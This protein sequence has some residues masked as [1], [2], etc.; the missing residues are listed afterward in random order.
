MVGRTLLSAN[1]HGFG[2]E[3]PKHRTKYHVT[4]NLIQGPGSA[5][6]RTFDQLRVLP[7]LD[8]ESSSTCGVEGWRLG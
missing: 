5:G 2:I 8:T 6:V 7:F 3:M 4:L 1:A